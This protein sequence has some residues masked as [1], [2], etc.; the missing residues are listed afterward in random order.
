[1]LNMYRGFLAGFRYSWIR[2]SSALMKTKISSS[3]AF[4]FS[5]FVLFSDS[6]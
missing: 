6:M 4:L 2:N 1:M 3:P 5:V